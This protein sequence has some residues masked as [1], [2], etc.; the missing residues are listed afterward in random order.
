MAG[1]TKYTHSFRDKPGMLFELMPSSGYTPMFLNPNRSG[2]VRE[3]LDLV[4]GAPR[5][6]IRLEMGRFA[7]RHAIPGWVR[8]LES[9]RRLLESLAET[10]DQVHA[11]A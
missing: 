5:S 8:G 4:R 3:Q 2:N 7:E 9:D 1:A 6:E 11:A 10:L